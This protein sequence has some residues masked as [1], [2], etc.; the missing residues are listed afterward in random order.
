MPRRNGGTSDALFDVSAGKPGRVERRVAAAIRAG[1]REDVIGALDDGACAL[2]LELARAVDRAGAA[3]T[4]P[5]PY[6]VTQAGR[7][8]RE[9]MTALRLTPASRGAQTSD[10]LADFLRSL[11]QDDTTTPVTT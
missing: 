3:G 11:E 5:D 4:K 8:L 7:E 6:A 10:A 2:A 9:V 1:K